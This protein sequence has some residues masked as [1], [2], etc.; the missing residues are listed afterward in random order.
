MNHRQKINYSD[1][2]IHSSVPQLRPCALALLAS[3]WLAFDYFLFWQIALLLLRSC[4]LAKMKYQKC[5]IRIYYHQIG[6]L[7]AIRSDE[8]QL[9]Y[10]SKMLLTNQEICAIITSKLVSTTANK[11]N[12]FTS[13][14]VMNKTCESKISL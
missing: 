1:T 12:M 7:K 9:K 8:G 4:V 2:Y 13:F 6:Y 10:F 11:Q 3:F 14:N 5:W